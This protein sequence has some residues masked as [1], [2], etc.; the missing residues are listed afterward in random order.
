MVRKVVRAICAPFVVIGRG[1]AWFV[2]A[3]GEMVV[4]A[5]EGIVDSLERCLGGAAMFIVLAVV[6]FFSYG[7]IERKMTLDEEYT[8]SAVQLEAGKLQMEFQLE[9]M[10]MQFEG[11]MT[12]STLNAIWAYVRSIT[13][14]IENLDTGLRTL[15]RQ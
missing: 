10:R 15:Q 11:A 9:Q 3:I 12:E 7:L 6:L 14:C 8:F 13:Q 4:A 2:E 5:K 1:F